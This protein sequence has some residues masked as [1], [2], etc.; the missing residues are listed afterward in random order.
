[1]ESRGDV[2]HTL[3]SPRLRLIPAFLPPSCSSV[4]YTTQGFVPARVF[5]PCLV[6]T[7]AFGVHV[8]QNNYTAIMDTVRQSTS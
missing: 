3:Y 1:M 4:A 7:A 8:I 5:V 6:A 2:S